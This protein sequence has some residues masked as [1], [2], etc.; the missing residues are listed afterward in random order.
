MLFED[1]VREKILSEFFKKP[2][3]EW[4]VKEL[5]RG[6][7]ISSGSASSVCK[8]LEKEGALKSE[9]K[10]RALFYS[11]RNDEP[12]VKRLKSTWF[13][14]RLM[15]LRRS[16]EN[17]EFVTVALYG[18]RASGE[19]ISISDIDILIISNVG[20][21][22]AEKNLEKLK[23]A[24]GQKLALTIFTITEWMGMSKR[25]EVFYMRVLSNHIILLGSS[26]VVG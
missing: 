16:W 14:S 6:L 19:F 13:L 26:L 21:E 15:K 24:F 8:E 1:T 4:Y 20:H 23:K 9:E 7:K 10:G 5:A 3:R 18:S 2:E 11:L 22:Q 17:P 12:L 25:K